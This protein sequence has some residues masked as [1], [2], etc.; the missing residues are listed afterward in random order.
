MVQEGE[1]PATRMKTQ[2]PL[3]TH[4]RSR[5][6]TLIEVLVIVAV[7]LV[8]SAMLLP[9]LAKAKAMSRRIACV[10]NEKNIGLGLRVF[11]TDNNE[12]FPWTLGTTNGG[13][14]EWIADDTQIWRHWAAVSNELSTPLIALCPADTE[15]WHR[16]QQASK[17]PGLA[18]ARIT[19]T[20]HISYFLSLLATNSPAEAILGGDRN[21]TTNGIATGRGRLRLGT[22]STV[23]FTADLHDSAGNVLLGDGSVQQTT[24]TDFQKAL[25]DMFSSQQSTNA[26][27]LI[28]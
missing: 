12:H 25:L 17:A 24:S 7:L 15:R 14:R 1:N 27:W 13:S 4:S 2:R 10:N 20:E 19:N 6:L 3:A 26:T 16:T 23:G 18:W 5:G 11:A 21:V 22:N 28:P 9:A 8:L